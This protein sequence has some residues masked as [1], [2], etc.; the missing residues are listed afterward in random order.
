MTNE[1]IQIDYLH[2]TEYNNTAE[3]QVGAGTDTGLRTIPTPGAQIYYV[4]KHGI[5]LFATTCTTLEDPIDVNCTFNCYAYDGTL[6]ASRVGGGVF[7]AGTDASTAQGCYFDIVASGGDVRLNTFGAVYSSTIGGVAYAFIIPD[8]TIY[9]GNT[10]RLYLSQTESTY[11]NIEL[12][13][14]GGRHNPAVGDPLLPFFHPYDPLNDGAWGNDDG[15]EIL[16]SETYSFPYKDDGGTWRYE[17][18]ISVTPCYL[19][20]T[21]GQNPKIK[22][23][24]GADSEREVSGLFNNET[25]I[26]WNENGTNVDTAATGYEDTWHDPYGTTV[27]AVTAAVAKG[28]TLVIYGGTGATLSP[29]IESA[30][31][32]TITV[33][34][35][36]FEPEYGY[37]PIL[38][39][40]GASGNIYQDGSGAGGSSI[41]GFTFDG[42][43]KNIGAYTTTNV[44]T[45]YNCTFLNLDKG[46]DVNP[47]STS[48]LYKNCYFENCNYGIFNYDVGGHTYTIDKNI[49]KNCSYGYYFYK[50]TAANWVLT[51]TI[52][53][54]IFNANTIGMCIRDATAA[55]TL[56]INGDIDNNTCYKN[57]YC[58][59]INDYGF[60]TITVNAQFDNDIFYNSTTSAFLIT[61]NVTSDYCC[62]YLNTADS[63][64]AGVLTKNNVITTDPLFCEI[65]SPEKFG[66]N[67]GSSCYRTGSGGDD[68]GVN[69][70]LIEINESD[71]E[72]NGIQIDGNLQYNN[73]IYIVD[74]ANHTGAEILWC[75][76][77]DFQGISIDLYDNDT[78]LDATV[79]NT[80]MYNNGV[81]CYTP[82]GTNIF[83]ENI[84][85]NNSRY[86]IYCDYTGYTF[87]HCVFYN[88]LTA[89]YI[90]SNGGSTSIKNC[91][92]SQNSFY[93][94]YSEINLT[95]TYCCLSGNVTTNV[96][97]TDDSNIIDNPLFINTTIGSENFNI[98]T[99]EFG[100][101]YNSLCK[102]ASD[103]TTFPDIGAYDVARSVAEDQ[104]KTHVFTYNP[105]QVP[106]N[107]LGKG[108]KVFE[109][110]LGSIDRWGKVFKR[111]FDLNYD[112]MQYMDETDRKKFFY[113]LTLIQTREN[114]LSEEETILRAHFLPYQYEDT[115]TSGVV[116]ATAKTITDTT[117]AWV[118]DEQKGFN[119]NVKFDEGDGTGS[120][121]FYAGQEV[122]MSEWDSQTEANATCT[123][124]TPG[125]NSTVG[126]ID[127]E[128]LVAGAGRR[129]YTEKAVTIAENSFGVSLYINVDSLTM[130]NAE[131]FHFILFDNS[132]PDFIWDGQLN[133]TAATEKYAILVSFIDDA[134]APHSTARYDLEAGDNHVVIVSQRASTA[135]ASDGRGDLYLNGAFCESQT[136]IDNYDYYG[137]IDGIRVGMVSG[138][139]A[140]T[141]GNFY[142][143]EVYVFDGNIMFLD[144]TNNMA[145]M[146]SETWTADDWIGYY[147]CTYLNSTRYYFFVKD[148]APTALML[149]DGNEY[150]TNET[151]AGWAITKSFLIESNAETVL[152][153]N[154]DDGELVSGTYDYDIDFIRTRVDST[155]MGY[156]QPR[157]YR[158]QENW[159]TGITLKLQQE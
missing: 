52:T 121:I 106:E 119:C 61:N 143:D 15:I 91:I 50:T 75:S 147:L 76:I 17:L 1:K 126:T 78:A 117:K 14:G 42:E 51:L 89:L 125:L 146:A 154:D 72:I 54:C 18:P 132:A 48:D 16:D 100:Y 68:V 11:Y 114:G 152:N 155:R 124:S 22:S 43:G 40:S 90:G 95:I 8:E 32:F 37:T 59:E 120:E 2:N 97:I 24:I 156:K 88:N 39:K 83:E 26:F 129:A 111:T 34:G 94:I 148:S 109:N 30:A 133:Y 23:I 53:D 112:S 135:V 6:L 84:V 21:D 102:D 103:D 134:S 79:S 150:L 27:N 63:T 145:V 92:F 44:S 28:V 151:E 159:K 107:L 46:I 58:V 142:C 19:Y 12:T 56:T 110:I 80:K 67:I 41:F 141:S 49:F 55:N 13:L 7:T 69:L 25:A 149:S 139:D 33:N 131:E 123:R 157:Y 137:L 81:G 93:D 71:I 62:F 136:G 74:V 20:S 66:L 138:V 101:G 73:A 77:F 64:G 57:S 87:K 45:I 82:Y 86:G 115:G 36:T 130:A 5:A 38:K 70:R 98:K 47:G 127:C 3:N 85:Y 9:D 99:Y 116:S 128:I 144:A 60:A 105:K 118:E 31:T 10:L 35:G 158:Q 104:W 96:D 29:T 108:I 65:T 113:F 122:D 4:R 140:G 153:L